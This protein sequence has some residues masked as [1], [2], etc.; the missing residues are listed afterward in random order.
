M[1]KKDRK[2]LIYVGDK[3]LIPIYKSDKCWLKNSE[4]SLTY[5]LF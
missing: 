2:F 1:T 5:V 3:E 4:N